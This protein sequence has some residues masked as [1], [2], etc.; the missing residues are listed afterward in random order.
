MPRLATIS[1]WTPKKKKSPPGK[2]HRL[3]ACGVLD[4]IS[5]KEA[6]F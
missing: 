6:F 4:K 3:D 5:F 2:L 1:P